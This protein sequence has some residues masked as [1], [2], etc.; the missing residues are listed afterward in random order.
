MIRRRGERGWSIETA[1]PGDTVVLHGHE[2]AVD[3]IY[4]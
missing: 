4:G 3:E 2:F 1:V